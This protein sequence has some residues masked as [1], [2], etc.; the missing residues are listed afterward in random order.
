MLTRH[1]AIDLLERLLQFEPSK[2]ITAA[3]GLSHHYFASGQPSPGAPVY[4]YTQAQ[5]TQQQQQAQQQQQQ[6]QAQQQQ[7]Q[8]R[9]AAAQ[10]YVQA[11]Q[12]AAA[13]A[14]YPAHAQIPQT[15]DPTAAAMYAQQY[16]QYPAQMAQM[17]PPQSYAQPT[18]QQ[19][20][21]APGYANMYNPPR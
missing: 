7:Q 20:Q 15:V 14:F 21:Y 1:A 17:P 6:Q 16:G 9:A 13:Q 5:I 11:Q 18:T 3:D 2:R 12:P 8:Q 19:A 10:A 4:S